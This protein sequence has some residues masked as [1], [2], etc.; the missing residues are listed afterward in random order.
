LLLRGCYAE[1]SGGS[2]LRYFPLSLGFH[3]PDTTH[4][5]RLDASDTRFLIIQ[6]SD[7]WY[8]HL[9]ESEEYIEARPRICNAFGSW[10]ATRLYAKFHNRDSQCL[11][12]EENL[13]FDLLSTLLK[14]N[15]RGGRPP[16]LDRAVELLR[17]E[18]SSKITV[19]MLA[20]QLGVHPIYLSRQFR[21]YSGQSIAGFVHSLRVSSAIVQ[22]RDPNVTVSEVALASGYSDQSQFTKAFA[23]RM[24]ITPGAFR[25]NVTAFT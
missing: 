20:R 9:R 12:S 21:R 13:V 18:F 5:D 7:A 16:W 14:A 3:P 24:G 22:L 15:T 1:R 6:L 4:T 11:L 25:K 23:R 2:T 10:L 17:C 19:T 8:E